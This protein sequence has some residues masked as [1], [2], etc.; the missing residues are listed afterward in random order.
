MY[1]DRIQ[2]IIENVHVRLLCA[3]ITTIFSDQS[4]FQLFKSWLDFIFSCTN[5]ESTFNLL[6]KCKFN[7]FKIF[8]LATILFQR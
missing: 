5:K 1:M 6:V 7:E 2:I 3:A 8:P 4:N